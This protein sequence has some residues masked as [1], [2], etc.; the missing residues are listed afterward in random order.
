LT[1]ITQNGSFMSSGT[2]MGASTGSLG[3]PAV[4]ARP[5]PQASTAKARSLVAAHV[6]TPANPASGPTSNDRMAFYRHPAD[7]NQAATAILAGRTLDVQ[8]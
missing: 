6:E 4:F 1:S 2:S 3:G 8:A 7:R 5:S